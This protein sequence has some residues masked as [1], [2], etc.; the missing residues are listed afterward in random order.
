VSFFWPLQHIPFVAIL[1][2]LLIF[3]A[4]D[5]YLYQADQKQKEERKPPQPVR[6]WKL[7]VEGWQN[8]ALLLGV[9]GAVI[10]SGLWHPD[11]KFSLF[12][13]EIEL[14]NAAL[15]V[16]LLVIIGLSQRFTPAKIRQD[17]SF[18]WEPMHEV[19]KLFAAI[20]VT[21]IPVIAML[22]AGADGAFAPIVH[23]LTS[24]DNHPVNPAYFWL[25][26]GFS[27]FVDNA[28]TYLVFFNIA[29][30]NARELTGPLAT[31][32]A[33]IS[34]GAVFMGA[35]SYIGN[36][37]NFMVKS[38]AESQGVKMPSFFAYMLW[39]GVI[40]TPCFLLITWI[41]FT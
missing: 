30:G 23:L 9:I 13:L 17:N 41:F 7:R 4:L 21:L 33:A 10:L 6:H 31:T 19:A 35:N 32:L 18:S 37:P 29:G 25:T 2:L 11:V 16:A 20:F 3:F 24:T 12:G 39:S 36:A 22:K 27:S 40:L 8:I 14:Q 34:A 5:S 26:G 15:D 1:Y 38:L 28:P